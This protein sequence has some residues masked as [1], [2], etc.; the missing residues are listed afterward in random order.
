MRLVRP[1]RAQHRRVVLA[2]ARPVCLH[3]ATPNVAVFPDDVVVVLPREVVPVLDV[4]VLAVVIAGDV[5]NVVQVQDT[6]R[7]GKKASPFKFLPY[8]CRGPE[9]L[10]RPHQRAVASSALLY[11]SGHRPRRF[12]LLRLAQPRCCFDYSHRRRR[13]P[14]RR[15]RRLLRRSQPPRL[16]LARSFRR[17]RGRTR[18]RG[19]AAAVALRTGREEQPDY[20]TSSAD[21]CHFLA[22]TIDRTYVPVPPCRDPLRWPTGSYA[23]GVRFFS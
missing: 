2:E 11:G 17:P 22:I 1:R 20:Q 6:R 8:V 3:Q 23:A 15:P 12:K 4:F 13:G 10:R 18:R 21:H 5:N 16:T 14:L 9:E 19:V 7:F